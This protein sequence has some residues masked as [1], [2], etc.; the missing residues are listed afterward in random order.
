MH[1]KPG[2]SRL[3]D[4]GDVEAGVQAFANAVQNCSRTKDQ[5]GSHTLARAA[6]IIHG[7]EVQC[8]DRLS[9]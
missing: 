4:L 3:C 6:C 9:A 5:K 1:Q 8:T 2:D 7:A